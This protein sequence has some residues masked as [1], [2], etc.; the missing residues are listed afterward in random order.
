[1]NLER[2]F[3]EN[4]ISGLVLDERYCKQPI[5]YLNGLF[6]AQSS[7]SSDVNT[8][9]LYIGVVAG[10]H[11]TILKRSSIA[12]MYPVWSTDIAIFRSDLHAEEHTGVDQPSL[13]FKIQL[14]DKFLTGSLQC[15]EHQSII[16]VHQDHQLT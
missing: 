6:V 11:P 15:S 5:S 9:L 16:D 7:F 2:K 4:K 3:T 14:V 10:A 1:M 12:S 8:C 13:K